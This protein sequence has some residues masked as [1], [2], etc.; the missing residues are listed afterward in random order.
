MKV[1]QEQWNL[2][3]GL[4]RVESHN[5]QELSH[6]WKW[7]IGNMNRSSPSFVTLRSVVAVNVHRQKLSLA[8]HHSV[9]RIPPWR[10]SLSK[11]PSNHR[12]A[13]AQSRMNGTSKKFRSAWGNPRGRRWNDYIQCGV[14]AS[15]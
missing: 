1:G 11:P 7:H 9:D 2:H 5:V 3:E 13:T 15:V 12:P 6:P 14:G 4:Y 10:V 8:A